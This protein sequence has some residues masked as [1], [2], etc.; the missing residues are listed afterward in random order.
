MEKKILAQDP[1]KVVYQ[2]LKVSKYFKSH[3]CH[4]LI[5]DL[6]IKLNIIKVPLSH[7]G[8]TSAHN[9]VSKKLF[10]ANV[11]TTKITKKKFAIG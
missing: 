10:L 4:S 8:E 1:D 11:S 7:L 5:S 2:H 9:R 3:I 6:N